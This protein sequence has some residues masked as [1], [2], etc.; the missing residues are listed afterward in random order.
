MTVFP[1][2]HLHDVPAVWLQAQPDRIDVQS[3][4]KRV[5]VTVLLQAADLQASCPVTACFDA[6]LCNRVYKAGRQTTERYRA[7]AMVG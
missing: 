7:L 5:F 3:V 4:D 2:L 1:V 6:R